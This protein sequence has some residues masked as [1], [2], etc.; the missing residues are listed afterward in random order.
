MC[1]AH[2]GGLADARDT[3]DDHCRPTLRTVL[4][5]KTPRESGQLLPRKWLVVMGS[6]AGTH[7][8]G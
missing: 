1:P 7:A 2:V 4:G 3:G 6:H 8:R 5:D